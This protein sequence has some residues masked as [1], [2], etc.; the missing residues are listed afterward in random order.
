MFV[1]WPG[2]GREEDDDEWE[3]GGEDGAGEGP[4]EDAER[5]EDGGDGEEGMRG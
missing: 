4:E 5:G 2:S 1:N 3:E